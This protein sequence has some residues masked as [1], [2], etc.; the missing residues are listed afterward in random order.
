VRDG[1]EHESADMTYLLGRNQ[2]ELAGLEH[3]ARMSSL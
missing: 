3:Q 1:T 2:T